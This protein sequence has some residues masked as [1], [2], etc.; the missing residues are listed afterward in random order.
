MIRSARVSMNKNLP[1]SPQR[2]PALLTMIDMLDEIADYVRQAGFR[3]L[4]SEE[5]Q[6]HHK[7]S[8]HVCTA[9]AAIRRYT[10]THPGGMPMSELARV[11]HMTPSAATHMVDSMARQ[12]MIIRSAC[13]SDRRSVLVLLTEENCRNAERV[14][15]GQLE[16]GQRLCA[17]LTAGE[18]Q[19]FRRLLDKMHRATRAETDNAAR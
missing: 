12:G 19:T 11:M 17:L 2:L 3:A 7:R 1:S 10:R 16:A 6:R 4:H 8:R 18:R 9:F 15:Q 13:P 14:E 5:R